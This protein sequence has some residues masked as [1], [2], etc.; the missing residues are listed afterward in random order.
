[1]WRQGTGAGCGLRSS[2][3]STLA[4]FQCLNVGRGCAQGDP[5]GPFLFGYHWTLLEMQVRNPSAL[6]LDETYVADAPMPALEAML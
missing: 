1:M 4:S 3:Q 5:L 6:S 2:R